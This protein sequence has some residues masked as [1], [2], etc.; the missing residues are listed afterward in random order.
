MGQ[1]DSDIAAALAGVARGDR[2]AFADLY[3]LAAPRLF[4]ATLKLLRRRDAAEDVLQETFLA[5]WDKAGQYTPERG[6]PM[7]W[8]TM[9]ARHRAIDRLRR[10]ARRPE[11]DIDAS[12]TALA[13]VAGQGDVSLAPA[14]SDLRR[15]LAA[16]D[17]G[18]REAILLAFEEGWTHEELAA[19]LDR[20]VGTVKSWIR[21]GLQRLKECLER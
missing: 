7:A 15:C 13:V 2:A 17:A 19:R 1:G 8:M 10:E 18:P 3:R 16:L 9:I 21:R 4:G 5:I 6:A 11:D 20:P 12:E 14:G